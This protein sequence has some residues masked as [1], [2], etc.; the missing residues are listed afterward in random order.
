MTTRL[1]IRRKNG[2]ALQNEKYDIEMIDHIYYI[3]LSYRK[4]RNQEILEEIKLLDPDLKKTTRINAIKHEDGKI[5]CAASHKLAVSKAEKTGYENVLILEDDF[6]FDLK[7][8]ILEKE[9]LKMIELDNNYNMFLLDK[10]VKKS[11]KLDK[12]I[13]EVHYTL[14]TGGYIVNKRFYK[15]LKDCFCDGKKNLEKGGN[16]PIDVYWNRIMGENKKIYTTNFKI[17]YQR[18]SYSDI[19]NKLQKNDTDNDNNLF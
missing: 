10:D 14:N 15:S 6:V 12:N 9:I 3:N 16:L 18:N 5:G 13:I 8:N 17:G 7:L 4:D 19:N 2:I 1:R 11:K